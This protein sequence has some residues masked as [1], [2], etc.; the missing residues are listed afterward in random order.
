MAESDVL[1][2]QLEELRGLVDHLN[3]CRARLVA[4]SE[5]R[6][7][8]LLSVDVSRKEANEKAAKCQEARRLVT[9]AKEEF[10]QTQRTKVSEHPHDYQ[11]YR[12]GSGTARRTVMT[13]TCLWFLA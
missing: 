3:D 9:A 11:P 6:S 13:W 10:E 12:R 4:E 7:A 1:D 5:P 2:A 8:R